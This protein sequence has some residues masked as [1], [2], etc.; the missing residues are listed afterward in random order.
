VIRGDKK[1][2][3]NKDKGDTAHSHS[4]CPI[5]MLGFDCLQDFR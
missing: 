5:E 4:D 1:D 2:C 3:R